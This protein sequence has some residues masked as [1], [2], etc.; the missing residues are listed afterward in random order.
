MP[1]DKVLSFIVVAKIV[2]Q[3]N[4]NVDLKFQFRISDVCVLDTMQ[5]TQ[6][7]ATPINYIIS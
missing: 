1:R 2:G 3:E 6:T 5:W 7:I 4:I